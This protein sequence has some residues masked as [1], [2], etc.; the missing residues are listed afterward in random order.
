MPE[1]NVSK[2]T[3]YR[4]CSIDQPT[5]NPGISR[6]LTGNTDRYASVTMNHFGL[7]NNRLKFKTLGKLPIVLE[8]SI[9]YTSKNLHEHCYPLPV[10]MFNPHADALT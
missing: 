5:P 2:G 6:E 7:R 1:G 8:D 9:E 4:L 3:H 10:Y